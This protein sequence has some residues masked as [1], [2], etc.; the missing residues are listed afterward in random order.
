LSTINDQLAALKEQRILITGGAG[1]IGSHLVDALLK[2]GK[3]V[4]VIDNLSSGKLSN[5]EAAQQS[6]NFTLFKG[7]LLDT[8]ST[9]KALKNC[10]LVFH[11]AANPEVRTGAAKPELHFQQNVVAT[12]S[13]LEAVRQTKSVKGLV[14]SSSSTV[15][16]EAET[17]PTSEDY[18]P[19]KPMSIYGAAKL[20]SEGL[21]S[22]YAQTY[23]FRASICRLA[24]IIGPRAQIGVIRDFIRKLHRTPNRLEILGDGT[25][26][27]SYLHV[28]DCV[29]CLILSYVL[30]RNQVEIINVGSEDQVSVME[31]AH[32]VAE[33]MNL[34]DVDFDCTGGVDGGRGW[35]GDVKQMLLDISRLKELG[36]HPRKTSADAVRDAAE[37]LIGNFS[38][39]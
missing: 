35:K 36:W 39:E 12:F 17:M 14:F 19:L 15:Y 6:P 11:L 38:G 22:S 18:A 26:A 25:Q 32:I 31:I 5:L 1:F 13:L 37:A 7:D 20:A 33:V 3:Q 28:D 34:T 21:I 24:N 16:G 29:E 9:L 2:Q 27:K 10:E 8:A 23:G 30:T 4:S